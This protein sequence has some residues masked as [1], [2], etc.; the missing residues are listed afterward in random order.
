MI[1]DNMTIKLKRDWKSGN[2]QYNFREDVHVTEWSGL[3]FCL[4]IETRERNNSTILFISVDIKC[5]KLLLCV[6]VC[7][8]VC[9]C[10]RALR[11]F[12]YMT[13]CD[14]MDHSLP[15][16][17]V[18]GILQARILEWVAMPSSIEFSWPRVLTLVSCMAG[19]FLTTEPL[20]KPGY[21]WWENNERIQELLK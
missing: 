6:R 10:A 20:G 4:E 9:V 19:G 7:V 16:F 13:P 17:F 11:C 8:C 12:N 2:H 15:G 3:R 5:N 1:I 21:C 14:P 18:H